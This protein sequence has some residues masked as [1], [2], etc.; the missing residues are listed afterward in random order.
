M[1]ISTYL[2]TAVPPVLAPWLRCG[3]TLGIGR[4]VLTSVVIP[5][6]IRWLVNLEWSSRACEVLGPGVDL[7]TLGLGTTVPPVFAP[8]FGV[9]LGDRDITLLWTAVPTFAAVLWLWM[10][11]GD[12]R[13][14]RD[15][16][17]SGGCDGKELHVD[18]FIFV[19]GV[20]TET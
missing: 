4:S 14:R 18:S 17:D 7:V 3:I 1:A 11:D 2:R 20:R 16:E 12:S 10:V 9:A 15:R 5:K 8:R 13:S 19:L 6:V